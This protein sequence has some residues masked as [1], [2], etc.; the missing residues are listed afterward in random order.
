[1]NLLLKISF[2]LLLVGCSNFKVKNIIESDLQPYVTKFDNLLNTKTNSSIIFTTLENPVVGRCYNYGT[3]SE[4]NII[5]IDINYWNSSLEDSK[6]QLIF[7]ELG[8][9]VLGLGHDDTYI[10]DNVYGYIPSSLMNSFV[11]SV[12]IYSQFKEFYY[13][14]LLYK[15]QT[16]NNSV[17]LY[18]CSH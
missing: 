18:N 3:N 1:M 4:Y 14:D 10:Y 16:D 8:H 15:K 2:I 17:I 9:C 11:I 6:E 13:Q 5:H 7:H 12:F